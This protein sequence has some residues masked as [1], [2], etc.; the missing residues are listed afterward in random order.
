MRIVAV[1]VERDA[2]PGWQLVLVD[3]SGRRGHG[4]AATS[5]GFGS[6]AAATGADMR[7]LPAALLGCSDTGDLDRVMAALALQSSEATY[8]VELALLDLIGQHRGL[9]LAACLT[10]TVSE[11]PIP[12]HALIRSPDEAAECAASALKVKVGRETLAADDRRLAGIRRV[13]GPHVSI[14]L[15]ANGAWSPEEAIEALRRLGRHDVALVEQPCP[16][17]EGLARVRAAVDIPVAADESAPE[18]DRIL[19]LDAAD[20]LVLK[21]MFVGGLRAA[22]RLAERARA[23]DLRISVTH[24]LEGTV[25]RLGALHLAA[26][27]GC[28]DTC[29]VD[30]HHLPPGS[31]LGLPREATRPGGPAKPAPDALPNPVRS[32]ALACPS[33]AALHCQTRGTWTAAELADAVARRAAALGLAGVRPGALVALAG[34]DRAD[35]DAEW[36]INFHAIGWLGAAVLPLPLRTPEPT[37]TRLLERAA[38]SALVW[39]GAD[40]LVWCGADAPADCDVPVIRAVDHPD[41]PP[42]PERF[43]PLDEVRAVVATSGTTGVP[44]LVALRTIQWMTSAFGS[45]IRL[46]HAPDDRW[47]C[48]LPLHHVGGLSILIRCAWYATAVELHPRFDP[49]AVSEAIDS[50][51]TTLVSLVPSMLDAVQKARAWAPFPPSLRAILLGGAP[52]SDRLLARC[53]A[54]GAPVAVTWGMTEA[55]SQVATRRPGDAGEGRSVGA[56]L[57]FARVTVTDHEDVLEVRG[58]LVYGTLR[59]GDRGMVGPDG[60]VRVL[61]RADEVI[62]SGGENIDPTEVEAVLATHPA[63]G[64]AAVLGIPDARWGRRP[65]AWLVGAEPAGERPSF[66]ELQRH[67]NEH[68][69][70]FKAPDRFRWVTAIPRSPLGKIDRA[71]LRA[72]EEEVR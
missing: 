45:A 9:P 26:A 60:D 41:L 12:R 69:A 29:G 61:G 57:A 11:A 62:V 15:D 34:S 25:G 40:A 28:E 58:P 66:A 68:L 43:W 38:P 56:P 3:S 27:I 6:G 65:A 24:A 51:R 52:A 64:E 2:R 44:R 42:A 48:C 21:P 22:L 32:A 72:L 14:R 8:A 54:I 53:A 71:G 36:V 18:L 59:T 5:P 50:G 63:V 20:V 16:T 70:G 67:C 39:C 46:G 47:L 4:E 17:V 19:A 7:R 1:R 10:H 49:A 37:R 23:A 35:P 31:G 13:A 55:A 30:A 33:R